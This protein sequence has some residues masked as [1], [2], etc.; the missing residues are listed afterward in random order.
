MSAASDPENTAEKETGVTSDFQG[1][2]NSQGT[3]LMNVP[4]RPDQILCHTLWDGMFFSEDAPRCLTIP[5]P[6]VSRYVPGIYDPW[7]LRSDPHNRVTNCFPNGAIFSDVFLRWIHDNPPYQLRNPIE[8]PAE[9]LFE[10][11]EFRTKTHIISVCFFNA[12]SDINGQFRVIDHVFFY[13]PPTEEVRRNGHHNIQSYSRL[14]REIS[15]DFIERYD[16]RRI[17]NQTR[18]LRCRYHP[19]HRFAVQVWVFRQSEEELD[20]LDEADLN[21]STDSSGTITPTQESYLRQCRE[22]SQQQQISDDDHFGMRTSE[23]SRTGHERRNNNR[24][25]RNRTTEIG[26]ASGFG[27]NEGGED[28]GEERAELREGLMVMTE[29]EWRNHYQRP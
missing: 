28:E 11:A 25:N 18:T 6:F 9:K 23:Q 17:D 26:G 1:I 24:R 3:E 29:E 19:H 8:P 13:E 21:S 5:P 2:I 10:D 12:N 4:N 14:Y 15:M 16:V 20:F 22:Q 7:L 27:L